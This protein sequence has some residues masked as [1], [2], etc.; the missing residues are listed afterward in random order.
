M[1]TRFL[2][3]LGLSAIACVAAAGGE[4]PPPFSGGGLDGWTAE[5]ILGERETHYSVVDDGGVKVVQA[6]C[7][8]SASMEG[9]AAPVDL[10][11]TPLL[12][13]RWKIEHL[14]PGLDERHKGGS[15]FPARVY[16]VTGKRWLPWTLH[17]IEYAWSNGEY[18]GDSWPSPYSGPMG[19]ALIVPVRVGAD[20]VGQWQE[21][22]RDV[23][24]DFKQFFNLDIDKI[25]ALAIM[26]DCDDSHGTGRAW[27]GDLH[28]V[29]REAAK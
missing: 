28:F 9:W 27:Y 11:K 7:Q 24:A 6:Q 26:T 23:R 21:Q 29:N 17:T 20:G 22:Q 2:L 3:L 16:V 8:D 18:K 1:K 13:W 15:D 25:G 14:Y 5:N 12:S 4:Q 10:A 19:P